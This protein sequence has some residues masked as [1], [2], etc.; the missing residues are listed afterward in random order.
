MFFLMSGF[1]WVCGTLFWC[2][3]THVSR[4]RRCCTAPVALDRKGIAALQLG[5]FP[6]PLTNDSALGFA[7]VSYRE[8]LMRLPSRWRGGVSS[9]TFGS[10]EAKA[11]VSKVLKWLLVIVVGFRLT[12]VFIG[13]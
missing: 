8:P 12:Q 10:G 5:L 6:R 2:E 13:N 11:L 7:N 4:L 3:R 1:G 9:Q